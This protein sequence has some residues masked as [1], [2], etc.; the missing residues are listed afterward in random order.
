MS[1]SRSSLTRN[2]DSSVITVSA[3]ACRER[4]GALVNHL[5]LATRAEGSHRHND[6]LRADH[7]V[8]RPT[9]SQHARPGTAQFAMSP[10]ELTCSAPS[11]ATST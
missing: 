11:T 6:A 5:R 8:H 7:E 10:D 4:I 9:H 2:T 3:A 1:T